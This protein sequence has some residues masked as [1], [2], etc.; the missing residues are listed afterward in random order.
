MSKRRYSSNIDISLLQ[1]K[2]KI[3][4]VWRGIGLVMMILLPVLSY[5]IAMVLVD[6]NNINHW[7]IYPEFLVLK[8]RDPYIIVKGLLAIL[9]VF[10]LYVLIT[11][12]A[13]LFYKVF[14]LPRYGK[15][16][17]PPEYVKP[18]NRK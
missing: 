11:F 7:V 14:G 13:A 18:I 12:I 3:H 5:L 4:P 6:E 16:D 10:I 9:I 1:K 17:V 15:T 8:W 2:K